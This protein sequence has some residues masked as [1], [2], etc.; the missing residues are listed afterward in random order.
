[1]SP[2]RWVWHLH[3]ELLE[4]PYADGRHV[5]ARDAL[6]ETI[7]TDPLL[8]AALH[9]QLEAIA[10]RGGDPGWHQTL[11][12]AMAEYTGSRAAAA[13]VTTALVS[14]SSGAIALNKLTPGA[15]SLGP[16]LAAT[17]AQQAAVASFP[18]GT[19]LGAWWY[20]MFPVAPS[21]ALVAGLTG[22]LLAA[23]VLV[24]S[25]AGIV[26]DPLQRRL[27][28][29]QRRLHR[30]LDAMQRQL[31][32]PDAPGFVAHDHYVARLLD[33]FDLVGAAYRLAMR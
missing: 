2:G 1:M 5:F 13:E 14:L 8:T 11:V 18:L 6:A 25:F 19:G 17:L 33:M 3:A 30:M 24:A 12:H 28:L 9:E 16:A 4:L 22:G 20:G 32:Q 31:L 23:A 21:A 7:L 26:A 27:G 15:L 29:H 10:A